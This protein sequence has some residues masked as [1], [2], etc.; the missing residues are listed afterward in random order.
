MTHIGVP[1]TPSA[2]L[3]GGS[4]TTDVPAPRSGSAWVTVWGLWFLPGGLTDAVSR[5]EVA[6][7]EGRAHGHTVQ[8]KQDRN[9][10]PSVAAV[11]E[12]IAGLDYHAQAQQAFASVSPEYFKNVVEEEEAA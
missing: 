7:Y 4:V 11:R 2:K 12:V 5:L 8:F 10:M 1:I 3:K 9:G 6:G